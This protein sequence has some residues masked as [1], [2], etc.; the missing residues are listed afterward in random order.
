MAIS[1]GSNDGEYTR[2]LFNEAYRNLGHDQSHKFLIDHITEFRNKVSYLSD[3]NPVGYD[4][5]ALAIFATE[6]LVDGLRDAQ[7][8]LSAKEKYLLDKFNEDISF[9][10]D[11]AIKVVSPEDSK[12]LKDLDDQKEKLKVL[13]IKLKKQQSQIG[14]QQTQSGPSEPGVNRPTAPIKPPPIPAESNSPTRAGETIRYGGLQVKI[15]RG[16]KEAREDFQIKIFRSRTGESDYVRELKRIVRES[17]F[18]VKKKMQHEIY[19][20]LIKQFPTDLSPDGVYSDVSYALRHAFG[21][22]GELF[23]DPEVYSDRSGLHVQYF[24][25]TAIDCMSNALGSIKQS[26]FDIKEVLPPE[27]AQV[28]FLSTEPF[29]RVAVDGL[30]ELLVNPTIENR[31]FAWNL[32]EVARS[33]GNDELAT[34]TAIAYTHDA[35][36]HDEV[37]I[38]RSFTNAYTQQEV[39]NIDTAILDRTAIGDKTWRDIAKEALVLSKS[40]A[41]SLA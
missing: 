3:P 29:M 5:I 31:E 18:G 32:F 19:S 13:F 1:H 4:D 11:E 25:N 22:L 30:T 21:Q 9:S 6:L 35:Y 28:K 17:F 2:G 34:L 15:V 24:R 41:V 8:K 12:T 7:I 23:V 26:Q 38:N 39:D 20:D 40:D 27:S 37:E 33:I 16:P 36:S 10:I 14:K